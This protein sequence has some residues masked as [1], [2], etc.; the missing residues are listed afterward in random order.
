MSITNPSHIKISKNIFN[1]IQIY[2]F[3]FTINSKLSNHYKI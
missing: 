1:V 3:E 2:N